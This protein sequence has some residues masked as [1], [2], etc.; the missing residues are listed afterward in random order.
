MTS[1]TKLRYDFTIINY[2][3]NNIECSKINL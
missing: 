1:C 3:E 2:D